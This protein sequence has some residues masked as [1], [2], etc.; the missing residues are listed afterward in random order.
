MLLSPRIQSHL[1]QL[2]ER[3]GSN[4]CRLEE[5]EGGGESNDF[6]DVEPSSIVSQQGVN[7][8]PGMLVPV[9][10]PPDPPCKPKKHCHK[11]KPK[12]VSVDSIK[13]YLIFRQHN[14]QISIKEFVRM[15]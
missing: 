14:K 3:G 12:C 10:D 1:E 5:R 15:S 7:P 6:M 9:L 2:R 13:Q 4:Q 11:K 8:G